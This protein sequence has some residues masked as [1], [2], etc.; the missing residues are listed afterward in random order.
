MYQA[1]EPNRGEQLAARI[2]ARVASWWFPAAIL[3]AVV[4]WAIINLAARPFQPYPVVVL[5]WI[6]A[7]LATVAA[8]Q[9][10]L[11]LLSQ[12]RAAMRD[13]QR[14]EEAFRVAMNTEADLH[15]V[16]QSV[17]TLTNRVDTL[18]EVHESPAGGE[19]VS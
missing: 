8:L 18:L 17:A 10:P 7:V 16:S 3:A 11:I 2:A 5:A 6:S 15:R 19:Q 14:D 13:R 12:R 9:G 1:P 4:L